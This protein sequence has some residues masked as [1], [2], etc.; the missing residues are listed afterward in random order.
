[1]SKYSKVGRE[2]ELEKIWTAVIAAK[3]RAAAFEKEGKAKEAEKEMNR[4]ARIFLE[5]ERVY[6]S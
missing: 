2:I 4:A 6:E 3:K 5:Y 1:M